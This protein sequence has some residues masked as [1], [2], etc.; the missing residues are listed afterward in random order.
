MVMGNGLA[1]PGPLAN[2]VD[3]ESEEPLGCC[4]DPAGW[5][6]RNAASQPV[7]HLLA[8]YMSQAEY[9][10]ALAGVN[11]AI[12]EGPHGCCVCCVRCDCCVRTER[13]RRIDEALAPFRQKGL[14]AQYIV[15]DDGDGYGN[16]KRKSRIR[17]TLPPTVALSLG[18]TAPPFTVKVP[19][20]GCAGQMM[21]VQ[22]PN[23]V[24]V[25]VQI[26]PGS[27]A[28]SRIQVAMPAPAGGTVPP[29]RA[30]MQR[31]DMM[32]QGPGWFWQ[33]SDGTW[34]PYSQRDSEELDRA[35]ASGRPNAIV[36]GVYKV[37]FRTMTQTNTR[38]RFQR[39]VWCSDGNAQAGAVEAAAVVVAVH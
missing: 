12:D 19:P 21:Q 20:N 36:A 38:T 15:G 33:E 31:P 17:V 9:S 32:P 23:G 26:P 5:T 18:P 2:Q 11:R 24:T 30:E 1:P 3:I 25:Q 39:P 16:G 34:I 28:G 29:G 6:F 4:V 10:G 37:D 22:A 7:P 27:V 35:K 8:P 14:E 13:I